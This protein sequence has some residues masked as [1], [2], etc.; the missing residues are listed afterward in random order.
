MTVHQPTAPL[1]GRR[2]LVVEDDYFVAQALSGLLEEADAAIAGPV[3]WLDETLV[4]VHEHGDKFD[5]VVLDV[6]LHGEKSYPVADLLRH[7]E[8]RFVFTTGYGV[9]ALDKEYRECPRCEKPIDS[10]MLLE[11]LALGST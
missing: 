9:D 7:L 6:D 3:G 11:L 5:A 2:I 4:F 1:A 10:R 8:I